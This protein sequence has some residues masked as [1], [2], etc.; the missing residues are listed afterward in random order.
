MQLAAPII[1]SKLVR[2]IFDLGEEIRIGRVTFSRSGFS[3]SGFL[4]GKKTVPWTD[5][6]FVPSMIAGSVILMEDKGGRAKKFASVPMSTPNA[7]VIP[8]LVQACYSRVH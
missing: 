4:G 3:A 1:V 5:G 8:D 2:R 6:I 7:A